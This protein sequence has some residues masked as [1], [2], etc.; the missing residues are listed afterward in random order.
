MFIFIYFVYLPA[1]LTKLPDIHNNS[2]Q[3]FTKKILTPLTSFAKQF[4]CAALLADAD[5]I[6][7]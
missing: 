3:K 4:P 2:P 7:S 6:K 5:C 1:K